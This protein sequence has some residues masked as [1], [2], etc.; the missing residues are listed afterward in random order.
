MYQE[1]GF[2]R[3]KYSDSVQTK[4]R[5]I[6]SPISKRNTLALLMLL[7]YGVD[8]GASVIWKDDSGCECL[9]SYI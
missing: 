5:R 4:S 9:T 7:S 8:W 3:W 1:I 6:G 2:G